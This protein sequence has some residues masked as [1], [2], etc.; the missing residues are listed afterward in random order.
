VGEAIYPIRAVSKLTGLSIDTLR[1]WERRYGAVHPAR[2]NRGRLYDE[3]AVQR[4][5]LLRSAVDRGHAIGQV[6][7]M[8]DQRL[9][10]LV[11]PPTLVVATP[12]PG[13]G[14]RALAQIDLE[15]ILAA[16]EAFDAVETDRRLS[17]YAALL[18]P[19][20]L[21]H[22]VVLPLMRSVGERWERGEL[23]IAREHLTSA[24][25][26]SLLGTLIRV[27]A[28]PGQKKLLFAT[29]SGEHHEFGILCA[30]I[31][32]IGEGWAAVFLG[33]NLPAAEIADAAVVTGARAVVLGYT[34]STGAVEPIEGIRAV[35]ERLP[36]SVE[37]WVGGY[38][39]EAAALEVERLPVRLLRDFAEFGR[40][41]ERL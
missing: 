4:L 6:A 24:S 39:S 10:Q 34:G 11:S 19:R 23:S 32:A 29:T 25:I 22:Q 41:L 35:R 15:P 27:N 26:R 20:E 9:K 31:L 3:A 36:T 1:A 2:S 5:I 21:V 12:E 40:S 18:T 8:S 17:R 33:T 14:A 7:S 16:V 37:V 13:T 38:Q 30:A 28:R